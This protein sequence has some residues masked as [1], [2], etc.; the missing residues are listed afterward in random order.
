MTKTV[1][2]MEMIVTR[3]EILQQVPK[4]RNLRRRLPGKRKRDV[5]TQYSDVDAFRGKQ[6]GLCLMEELNLRSLAESDG[7][8]WKK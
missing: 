5:A 7:E 4:G 6:Q 1:R 2:M 8:F 3:K